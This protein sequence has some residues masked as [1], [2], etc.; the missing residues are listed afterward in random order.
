MNAQA[1]A[2]L[3]RLLKRDAANPIERLSA[4][5]S[6]FRELGLIQEANGLGRAIEKIC[7]WAA[8]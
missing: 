5:E 4:L 2:E 7:D 1:K 3:V 6:K 8:K